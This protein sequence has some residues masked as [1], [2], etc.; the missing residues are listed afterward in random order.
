[1]LMKCG[2]AANAT[3][4]DGSPCCIICTGLTADADIVA[5]QPNFHDRV[6]KCADCKTVV[7]SKTTLPF[8]EYRPMCDTDRYYCGC[9]GW[10]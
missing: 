7:G 3:K 2:H 5:E 6:A 8:F 9:R 10:E 4:S 1:M